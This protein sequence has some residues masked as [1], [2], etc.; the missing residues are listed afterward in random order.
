MPERCAEELL[1]GAWCVGRYGSLF[2]ATRGPCTAAIFGPL[3]TA[4]MFLMGF[5]TAVLVSDS[6]ATGQGGIILGVHALQF[7]LQLVVPPEPPTWDR[8]LDT[9]AMATDLL[10]LVIAVLPDIT[11][12]GCGG[13]LPVGTQM[14]VLAR[15][16]AVGD[17][18][19][20]PRADDGHYTAGMR[21]A[22]RHSEVYCLGN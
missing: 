7:V 11:G 18:A 8:F 3:D 16:S 9:F 19:A 22:L 10:P 20:D 17:G 14:L 12:G 4:R 5:C 1:R 15:G 2:D 6:Q 13:S 21:A